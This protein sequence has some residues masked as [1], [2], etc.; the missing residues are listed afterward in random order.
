LVTSA[1]AASKSSCGVARLG[2]EEEEEGG[3][4]SVLPLLFLSSRVGSVDAQDAR[5]HVCDHDANERV[6]G[7]VECMRACGRLRCGRACANE[8]NK[9]SFKAHSLS[10][11]THLETHCFVCVCVCVV[12]I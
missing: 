1:A 6:T 4:W 3:G 10:K 7:G 2:E 8:E 12:A 9:W 11:D 5:A